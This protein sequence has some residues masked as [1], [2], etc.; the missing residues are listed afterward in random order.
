MP[1]HGALDLARTVQRVWLNM[2]FS[3]T[4]QR[5]LVVALFAL[6]AGAG[7]AADAASEAKAAMEKQKVKSAAD[8]KKA[9]EEVSKQRD[10]FISEYEALARQLKA[11]TEEQKQQIRE[12]MES[13]KKQFEDATNALHKAIRDEQ[14]K[15]RS[16]AAAKK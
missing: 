1:L 14:R 7:F 8:V 15:L 5:L 10:Q 9:L 3:S 2:A 12:K 16:S 11:A 13:Q 6:A 4:A